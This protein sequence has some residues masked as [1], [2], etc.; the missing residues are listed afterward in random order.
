MSEVSGTYTATTPDEPPPP[1]ANGADDS[2]M[3]VLLPDKTVTLDDG[4]VVTVKPVTFMQLPQG[5]R[6][7]DGVIRAALRSGVLTEHGEIN[8]SG[9]A[10][11][12]AEAGEHVNALIL[13]CT[14]IDGQ[15]IDRQWLERVSIEE[16]LDLAAAVIGVN[17]RASILKKLEALSEEM[18][19]LG[20]TLLDRLGTPGPASS[21]D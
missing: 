21:S 10:G 3:E 7:I 6:H 15:R 8:V 12:Y 17:W 5:A 9:L 20:R 19:T 16:G 13:L 2:G 4:D 1:G 14:Y 11:M 18:E